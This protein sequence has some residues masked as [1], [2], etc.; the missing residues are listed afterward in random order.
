MPYT[1]GGSK[2]ARNPPVPPEV[3]AQP[4]RLMRTRLRDTPLALALTQAVLRVRLRLL[5]ALQIHVVHNYGRDA[6]TF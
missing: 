2:Y 5:P 4:G 3:R 6:G 1:Y